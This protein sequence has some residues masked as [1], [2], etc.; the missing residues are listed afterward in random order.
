MCDTEKVTQASCSVSV[1]SSALAVAVLFLTRGMSPPNVFSR[2]HFPGVDQTR[3]IAEGAGRKNA[4]ETLH[5]EASVCLS[6]TITSVVTL[7]S[8]Y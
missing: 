5:G 4:E 3:R 8:L 2:A 6:E 7:E 1:G